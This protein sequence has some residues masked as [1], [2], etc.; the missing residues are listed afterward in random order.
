MRKQPVPFII[1][2]RPASWVLQTKLGEAIVIFAKITWPTCRHQIVHTGW[3]SMPPVNDVICACTK[4][5]NDAMTFLI[6]SSG[7]KISLPHH[8]LKCVKNFFR[9]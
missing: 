9:Y 8:I 1:Q 7:A 2:G 6:S 4:R 3:P 5:Q